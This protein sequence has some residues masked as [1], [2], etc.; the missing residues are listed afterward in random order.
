VV[1]RARDAGACEVQDRSSGVTDRQIKQ[2]S[3]IGAGERSVEPGAE[4]GRWDFSVLDPGENDSADDDR[5]G[6]YGIRAPIGPDA[7][8]RKDDG[9]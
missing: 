4:F 5:R 7:Q 1:G 9:R 6:C 8:P 2:R 3:I